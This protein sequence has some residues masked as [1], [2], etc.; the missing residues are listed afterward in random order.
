MRATLHADGARRKSVGAA[1]GAVLRSESGE[2]LGE[3]AK[4]IGMAT[5]NVAEYVALIE[6]LQMALD[7]GVTDLDAYIDS[8]VVAGHVLRGH[9]IK[10][11]HLRP[12]VERVHELLERFSTS[13]LRRVPRALNADA[14][15]LANQGLDGVAEPRSASFASVG[16]PQRVDPRRG[17]EGRMAR[18]SLASTSATRYAEGSAEFLAALD[19]TPE[20]QQAAVRTLVDWAES[21]EHIGL[22]RL[23]TTIGTTSTC[24]RVRLPDADTGPITIWNSISS[25][26]QIWGSALR[27]RAPMTFDRVDQALA[28]KQ[29]KLDRATFTG[30]VTPQLLDALK[31]SY[32]EAAD[33][34]AKRG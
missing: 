34:S 33:V 10:A 14:D 4:G 3:I 18:L 31:A 12:L 21:L 27:R 22:A 24:L 32:Q 26:V 8:P 7:K 15:R 20:T 30:A 11:E 25:P 13:S 19:R 9:K 2:V 16:P 29:L 17:Q 28:P 5:H 1:I 23:A 6:G